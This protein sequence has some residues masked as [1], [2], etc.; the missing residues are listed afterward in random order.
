MSIDN[1][2]EKKVKEIQERAARTP[3][4]T[5]KDGVIGNAPQQE[6][7]I[8]AKASTT[9]A[10]DG[11]LRRHQDTGRK[12]PV[13]WDE[14]NKSIELFDGDVTVSRTKPGNE[15]LFP[16]KNDTAQKLAYDI[17]DLRVDVEKAWVK[18]GEPLIATAD[19]SL[20]K[21]F[22]GSVDIKAADS[23]YDAFPR[24][25]EYGLPKRIVAALILN[26]VRHKKPKDPYEDAL[27]GM[28]GKVVDIG[29]GFK[30]NP[31]A[32]VGP[33]QMQVRNIRELAAKYPQLKRFDEPV[34]A[35]TNP[36]SAP[37]FVAAYLT[38]KIVQ[39][40]DF[41]KQHAQGKVPINDG[42]LFYLYNPD[43]VVKSGKSNP[44][45]DDYRA[46]TAWEKVERSATGKK[47]ESVSGWES[48]TMP[49]NKAVI[50]KSNIVR[51]MR[52]ALSAVEK[53]H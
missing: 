25:G 14:Q 28:F 37:Y 1:S 4:N 21:L 8:A 30:D 42:T 53:A 36:S 38:E 13:D 41:N 39:L 6:N 23:A 50:D 47:P 49:T 48:V 12:L 24:L 33:G 52:S 35:A 46:L 5:A 2:D 45:N 9:N 34:R 51:E 18:V 32:S 17:K 11:S 15:S 22:G 31:D 16:N 43:V 26:E 40:E 27:V 44:S 10:S 29:H 19:E 20:D 7:F 3:E